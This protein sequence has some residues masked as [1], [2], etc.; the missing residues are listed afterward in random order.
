M[1]LMTMLGA[2]QT[3]LHG[4][5]RYRQRR[6]DRHQ[7]AECCWS[8]SRNW[9][10][11]YPE[12]AV[13][14]SGRAGHRARA[15]RVDPPGAAQ[16]WDLWPGE[17]AR[18]LDDPDQRKAVIQQV[19]P[20]V[21]TAEKIGFPAV[22]GLDRHVEALDDFSRQLGR[23]CFEIP[24]LPPSV[25]G[26]RLSNRIRR[27]LL[28]QRVRVQ[29]GHPVV[30]GIVDNGRC[31][32]VEVGAL[33]HTNPFYAD[34]FILATGGLYNG[35]IQSDESGSLWEPIF[36]LPVQGPRVKGATGWYHDN[37]LVH[38]GHPIHRDAGCACEQTNAA[39]RS[40]RCAGARQRLRRWA[41]AGRI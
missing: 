4:S 29:I 40:G 9:R 8:D 32:G 1:R 26:T 37:L 16:S 14:K 21:Q 31:L 6:P 28:R 23:P 36:D 39:A 34:Q 20:H 27:W 2:I 7:R 25:P 15:I 22:L 38:R 24:T 18:Q 35:G 11:F 30:R 17:L 12:L 3:P 41:Y 13:Q 33:G 19:K 10:D 5:A